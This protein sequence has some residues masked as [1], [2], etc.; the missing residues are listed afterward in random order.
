[1][2][3]HPARSDLR[4]SGRH[5]DFV[6]AY[7]LTELSILINRPTRRIEMLLRSDIGSHVGMRKAAAI[8]PKLTKKRF[9]LVKFSWMQSFHSHFDTARKNFADDLAQHRPPM[10]IVRKAICPL[11]DLLFDP[12]R[13][14]EP[15]C[16]DETNESIKLNFQPSA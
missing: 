2:Q 11:Y 15:T 12:V 9:E 16:V 8:L 14:V 1:M 7:D 10:S 13:I 3:P 6:S 5:S 4:Q